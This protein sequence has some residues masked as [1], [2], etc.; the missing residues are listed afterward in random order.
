MYAILIVSINFI[1]F[2]YQYF[3]DFADFFSFN[4]HYFHKFEL[5]HLAYMSMLTNG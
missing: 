2:S 3:Y 5:E 1:R 4:V